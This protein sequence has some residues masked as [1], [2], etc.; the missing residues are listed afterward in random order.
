M[1]RKKPLFVMSNFKP[2]RYSVDW[3]SE[4]KLHP[5]TKPC[6]F[7]KERVADSAVSGIPCKIEHVCVHPF[8][9]QCVMDAVDEL[10]GRARFALNEAHTRMT[11]TNL[12][13]IIMTGE[14]LANMI[15]D[16]LQDAYS[17]LEQA[18][19]VIREARERYPRT[20]MANDKFFTAPV[21]IEEAQKVTCSVCGKEQCEHL[22]M[23]G[24]CD[25]D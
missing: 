15:A 2:T 3:Y 5:S 12:S 20:D 17:L 14:A 7:L 4:K 1:D 9:T 23:G 19:T 22:L 25:E 24:F 10:H 6:R 13:P 16:K 8:F 11:N 21:Y 18:S